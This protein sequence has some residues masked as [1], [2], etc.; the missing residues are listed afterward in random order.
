MNARMR[1]STSTY[2]QKRKKMFSFKT[3]NKMQQLDGNPELCE[4]FKSM[5]RINTLS[6]NKWCDDS[7]QSSFL[8]HEC[9]CHSVQFNSLINISIKSQQQVSV[10]HPCSDVCVHLQR[11]ENTPPDCSQQP[12]LLAFTSPRVNP[13]IVLVLFCGKQALKLNLL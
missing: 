5:H 11:L 4:T 13:T 9:S 1:Q 3:L 6:Q 2:S 12:S 8:Q 7:E 10:V